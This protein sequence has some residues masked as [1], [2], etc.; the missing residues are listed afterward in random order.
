MNALHDPRKQLEYDLNK[1][2]SDL[3]FQRQIISDF[4]CL[5]NTRLLETHIS[6][7]LLVDDKAYKIKKALKNDFLD[8]SQL[9][10]RKKFCEDEIQLNARYSSGLYLGL[11]RI[12]DNQGRAEI[13]GKGKTLDY[14]VCMRRF[15]QEDIL[16]ARLQSQQLCLDDMDKLCYRLCDFQETQQAQRVR[17]SNKGVLDS[18]MSNAECY[19]QDQTQAILNNF[20]TI[21]E[22]M[23]LTRDET[24]RL[25]H[26]E[27]H[28]KILLQELA[29]LLTSRFDEGRVYDGHGDLHLN[30][31][32]L[33]DNQVQFFDGIEFSDT[34]RRVDPISEL[35]F[36]IMDLEVHADKAPGYAN[37]LLNKWL[38]LSGDYQGLPLLRLF[39][40]YRAMVRAKVAALTFQQG[41]SEQREVF[42]EYLGLA[43]RYTKIQ[44]VCLSITR[45]L[46]GSGKSTHSM[47]KAMT[48]DAVWLRSDVERKRL[49]KHPDDARYSSTATE[50]VY[51][52]L[53]SLSKQLL[54]WGYSVIVDATFLLY[55]QRHAFYRLSKESHA[56]FRILVCEVKEQ[57]LLRRLGARHAAGKDVSEADVAV[58][59][60]QKEQQEALKSDEQ[61]YAL[62][63]S[64]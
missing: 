55:Q 33:L 2:R 50:K 46:S 59:Y 26:I 34:L 19:L 7:I 52:H 42:L 51:A 47:Q 40:I 37:Y 9:A 12:T 43:E 27:S 56:N 54:S 62:E 32:V 41:H 36:I 11:T 10:K 22:T 30:N 48:E 14:A 25:K 20:I 53:L 64:R 63:L 31:I 58:M 28:S 49:Y 13:D 35:A 61:H 1:E 57:E 21:R 15:P 8:Y 23:V 16:F 24:E 18:K 4:F 44:N 6:W 5:E 60:R 29:D 38:H 45:G 3:A 39:K 17:L